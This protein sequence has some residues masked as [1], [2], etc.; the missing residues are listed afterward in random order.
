VKALARRA[1]AGRLAMGRSVGPMVDDVTA[2]LLTHAADD[3]TQVQAVAAGLLADLCY[4]AARGVCPLSRSAPR[5]VD[6]ARA[7]VADGVRVAL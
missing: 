7:L 6:L 1:I 5:A 4:V 3:S 2:A